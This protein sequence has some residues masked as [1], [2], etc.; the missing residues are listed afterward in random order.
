MQI[1]GG[2]YK[3][4]L[5]KSVRRCLSLRVWRVEKWVV[6]HSVVGRRQRGGSTAKRV[7][8]SKVGAGTRGWSALA[9]LNEMR[10]QQ[11]HDD[12]ERLLGIGA[13]YSGIETGLK[14]KIRGRLP[15]MVAG[16]SDMVAQLKRRSVKERLSCRRD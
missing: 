6:R 13:G 15:G 14:R 10:H 16:A 12:D 8:G 4:V 7:I 2:T 3:N 11:R 9:W 1:T 5:S